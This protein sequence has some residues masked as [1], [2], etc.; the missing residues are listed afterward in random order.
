MN[1]NTQIVNN[2]IGPAAF[3]ADQ[4]STLGIL[5]FNENAPTISGNELRFIGDAATAGGSSGRD[6]VGISLCT[7]SASW[8]GTAAPTVVG[9]V[10]NGNISGNRI[11][12]IVDRATFSAAGIVENCTN[13]GNATS[14]TIANNFIYN[15]QSNGTSPDQTVGIGIANGNGDT[16]AFNSIYLTGDIDPGTATSSS[17][18]SFGISVN[19]ATPVNLTL[20]DNI[21]VMDLSSNTGTLLHSAINIPSTGYVWGTGGSNFNNWFAPAANPQSRV[22]TT[23]GSAGVFYAT[24]AAWQAAVVAQ[25]VNSLSVDPLF[26]SGTDLHLQAMS[27]MI[28]V[29]MTIPSITT[30]IDGDARPSG[31]GSE[32]GADEIVPAGTPGV[33]AFSSPTYSIGEAGVMATITVSRTGGSLGTVG[34]SY[35]TVAGGTAT[36]GAAC[37]GTVDYVNTSGMLS[38]PD[39]NTSQTFDI[40]ICSDSFDEADETVNLMLSSATGGATIGMQSTAVLTINDDDPTP[41]HLDQRC[42]FA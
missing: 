37:G 6:H 38:F 10:T 31:T 42:Q 21:S 14:N 29:G 20:K 19:V 25:D 35:A 11:H 8:S 40:P 18:S 16:V 26:V 5:I 13:A 23:G 1:Q 15:I 28:N 4:V 24:L 12:D 9:T 27:P 17:F 33:L 34:V 3:G 7:G 41:S 30:D 22:G 32:I 36:G 39:G 2:L